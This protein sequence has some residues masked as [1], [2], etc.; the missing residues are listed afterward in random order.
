M[1]LLLPLAETVGEGAEK[2]KALE[3][4]EVGEVEIS[5][6]LL[7]LNE[8]AFRLSG[9]PPSLPPPQYTLPFQYAGVPQ[10]PAVAPGISCPILGSL[11]LHGGTSLTQYFP[12]L[13]RS[14]KYILPSLPIC[15]S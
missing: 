5:P 2:L 12:I 7:A 3:V 14:I 10:T 9:P 1:P 11:P 15:V 4:T 6:L 8:N 13:L